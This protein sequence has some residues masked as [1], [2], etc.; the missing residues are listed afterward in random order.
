MINRAGD[1]DSG[2]AARMNP[3]LWGGGTVTDFIQV[4]EYE[5]DDIQALISAAN[6]VPVPDDV[7]KPSSVMVVRDRDRLGTYATIHRFK[8]H[9]DAMRHSET[10]ATRQ[11]MVK[12]APFV[13][14]GPRFYQFDLVD[15]ENP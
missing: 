1:P 8:S 10:D 12:I 15:E 4:V 9:R 11:R 5:S 14:G 13:K 7:P 6:S 2:V 3:V